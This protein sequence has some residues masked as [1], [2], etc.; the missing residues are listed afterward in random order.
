MEIQLSIGY[1]PMKLLVHCPKEPQHW[2]TP[3]IQVTCT[4]IHQVTPIAP[5]PNETAHSPREP[6]PSKASGMSTLQGSP[7]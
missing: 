5:S 4:S 3:S 1:S 7:L 2:L 6:S